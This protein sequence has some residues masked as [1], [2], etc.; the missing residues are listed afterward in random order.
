MG[1]DLSIHCA[2]LPKKKSR[3]RHH[4]KR[5]KIQNLKIDKQQQQQQQQQDEKKEKK[6]RQLK[7]VASGVVQSETKQHDEDRATY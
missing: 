4:L 7:V 6:K 5:I 1:I 3:R 2:F